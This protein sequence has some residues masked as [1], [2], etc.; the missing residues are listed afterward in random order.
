MDSM[1]QNLLIG[2]SVGSIA[3]LSMLVLIR[4]NKEEVVRMQEISDLHIIGRTVG[5]ALR[6]VID[7]LKDDDWL[8]SKQHI[9]VSKIRLDRFAPTFTKSKDAYMLLKATVDY[10]EVV[11]EL[12]EA[13]KWAASHEV[14]L[15]SAKTYN[16]FMDYVKQML[17]AV[18]DER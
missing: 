15:E 6:S 13:G 3:L 16:L 8:S 11:I 18:K 14:L 17:D 2:I 7:T 9:S 1:T 4:W 10:M 5:M 12:A